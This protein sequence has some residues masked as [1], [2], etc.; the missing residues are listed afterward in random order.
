MF[1][2][3]NKMQVGPFIPFERREK[4]GTIYHYGRGS[5]D[6][7]GC[8][9]AQITAAHKF[10]QSRSDTPGLGMLFVVGEEQGAMA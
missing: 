8:V 1:L 6:A 3:A 5:V 10:F 7:K 4:N 2:V 9:A